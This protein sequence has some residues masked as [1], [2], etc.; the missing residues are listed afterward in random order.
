MSGVEVV[1]ILLGAF[2]LVISAIEHYD[3]MLEPTKAF[4]KF[5]FHLERLRSQLRTLYTSFQLTT[6]ALLQPLVDEEKLDD[7]IENTNSLHWHDQSIVQSLK[8]R[9]HR[10]YDDYIDMMNKVQNTVLELAMSIENIKGAENLD[11]DGLRAIIDRHPPALVGGKFQN[12]EF[13]KRLKFTMRRRRIV[14]LLKE[15]QQNIKILEDLQR[16]TG[17]INKQKEKSAPDHQC[18]FVTPIE[19]IRQRA[20]SLYHALTKTW[21]SSHVSHSAGLLLEPRR[22]PIKRPNGRPNTRG[23]LPSQ[24]DTGVLGLSLQ[25]S[26]PKPEKW[27]EV[28]IQFLKPSDWV[29]LTE[30]DTRV[31]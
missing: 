3:D 10:G 31:Q 24:L 16:Q 23:L 9:L 20:R 15:L 14:S 29:L 2:P 17:K 1:G 27:T 12:F 6:N 11:R 28:E 21:C 30:Y 8:A 22:R 26:S 25:K 4:L 13:S 5:G 19:N 18:A 7:M